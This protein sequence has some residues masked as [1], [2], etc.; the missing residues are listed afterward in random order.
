MLCRLASLRLQPLDISLKL[1]LNVTDGAGTKPHERREPTLLDVVVELGVPDSETGHSL[2][3]TN[4]TCHDLLRTRRD[5]FGCVQR[6]AE[7]ITPRE[8]PMFETSRSVTA[9]EDDEVGHPRGLCASSG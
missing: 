7:R 3:G 1:F 5:Y 2:F 9:S 8:P 4:D 6:V